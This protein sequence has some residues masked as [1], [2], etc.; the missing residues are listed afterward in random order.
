MNRVRG[1]ARSVEAGAAQAEPL[2]AP[3]AEAQP[4]S[5]GQQARHWGTGPAAGQQ[6]QPLIS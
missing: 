2:G 1:T 4:Q 6:F 5:C 3:K